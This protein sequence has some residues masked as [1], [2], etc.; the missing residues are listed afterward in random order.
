M[1]FILLLLMV[2][3]N[4]VFAM[5]EMAII[6]ARKARLQQLSEAGNKK[7]KTA[8]A[9]AESP[10]HFLSTVQI[11][12]TLVGVLAGAVGSATI[13]GDL[14]K[15]IELVPF[16][17]PYSETLSLA[18]V[19]LLTTYLT[20]ILGELVPKR[21]ALNGPER[22]AMVVAQP[23]RFLATVA[24]PVVRLLSFSTKIVLRVLGIRP[25]DD[26]PVTE[27]ELCVMLRQGTQA[28]V[29]EEAEEDMVENVFRLNNLRIDALMTPRTEII[30]LDIHD[31]INTI[32]EKIQQSTYTRYPVCKDDP[33]N[34]LGIVSAKYLLAHGLNKDTLA[35]K[36]TLTPPLFVPES[37]LA[38][39]MVELF[40]RSETHIAVVID[41]Y[42]GT[43]GLLTLHDVLEAIVGNI[44]SSRDLGVSQVI[45]RED[46]SWLLDGML[47]IDEFKDL[48]EIAELPDEDRGEYQ[49][50]AGFALDQL[51]R[52][53]KEGQ[54]FKWNDLR[55]EVID[56][57][58]YRID[59][60]LI[61]PTAPPS[62][63]SKE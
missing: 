27:E 56:M 29:F 58:G 23:M 1:N 10:N 34:L 25:S 45:Q 36:D 2:L 62:E 51:D 3:A 38:S 52:L 39:R 48:F 60:I 5:S 24:S 33:D 13:A 21:L 47:R 17:T 31:P 37:M 11:G 16:L 42:G 41:E 26:P 43:Q 20:L 18:L 19:V 55:F 61:S 4:G 15:T 9:L 28:G 14:A 49:T 8:L 57:D 7:A 35:Q 50:L 63:E 46:G 22:I 54:T 53:P 44:L 32:R 59:K 6:S 30:W 12:I 40:K